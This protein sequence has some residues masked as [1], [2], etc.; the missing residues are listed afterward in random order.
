MNILIAPDSFKGSMTSIQAAEALQKGILSVFPDART[1]IFPIADGGEGTIEAVLRILDGERITVSTLDPLHRPIQASYGWIPSRKWAV[2]ET[3]AASGLPLLAPKE[4][5]PY[6]TS[7]YGTG[8]LIRDALD[9]GAKR[10]IVGLGGSA[11][12]DAGMGIFAAC[13]M[14][15]LDSNGH[16]LKPCGWALGQV[17][18]I[19]PSGMDPRLGKADILLAYDVKNPLLGEEGAVPIFGPQKGLRPEDLNDMEKRMNHFAERVIQATGNDHRKTEGSGAAGG[20]PFLFR[21]F[22]H[23]KA[24]SGFKWLA[25]TGGLEKKMAASDLVITGEGSFDHQSLSGKVPI[26]I[27]RMARK[28]GVPTVVFSGKSEKGWTA[29]PDEGIAGIYPIVDE[30]MYLDEAMKQGETLMIRAAERFALS[31]KLGWSLSKDPHF[32]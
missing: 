8:L 25:E 20:I 26:G 9:R 10:I 14:R 2:I 18:A 30:A 19:D 3:A 24:Q 13:G 7:S 1:F 12:V 21:S 32:R 11:T 4:R 28:F 22:F 16:E 17:A 27:S 6:R 5:D 29:F 23:P 15:F 31:L